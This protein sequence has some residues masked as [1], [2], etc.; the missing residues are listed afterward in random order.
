VPFTFACVIMYGKSSSLLGVAVALISFAYS[1]CDNRVKW[2]TRQ[3]HVLG[4]FMMTY[5][6]VMVNRG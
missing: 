1:Q 2:L 5:G 3:S 6:V 4:L